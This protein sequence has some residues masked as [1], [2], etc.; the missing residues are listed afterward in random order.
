[1]LISFNLFGKIASISELASVLQN[2][3][4]DFLIGNSKTEI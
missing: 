2:G 1:M 4:Y 3:E